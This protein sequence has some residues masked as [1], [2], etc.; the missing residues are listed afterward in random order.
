MAKIW[1]PPFPPANLDE[2]LQ[3]KVQSKMLVATFLG[4]FTFTALLELVK[5]PSA[6]ASDIDALTVLAVAALT[7]ALGLFVAAV[8]IYDFLS[9]PLAYWRRSP[10][11]EG[12][13]TPETIEITPHLAYIDM[14]R[15]WAFV[16]TPA[17]VL[18]TAGFLLIVARSG[19]FLL[20]VLCAGILL[21]VVLYW[22]KTRS[23]FGAD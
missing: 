18:A 23:A 16:F 22:S 15:A 1:Q 6:Q 11:G 20:A 12:T 10:E 2:Q 8:Y 19:R 13:G 7:G 14:K 3:S 21:A 5:D 9:T 4:G 17:V